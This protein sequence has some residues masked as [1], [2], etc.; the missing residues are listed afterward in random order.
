MAEPSPESEPVVKTTK[1]ELQ[2]GRSLQAGCPLPAIGDFSQ[3][4]R[5]WNCFETKAVG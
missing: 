5:Q 3:P 1:R 2:N 4:R